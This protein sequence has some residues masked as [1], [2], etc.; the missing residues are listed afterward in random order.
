MISSMRIS[1]SPSKPQRVSSSSERV[2]MPLPRAGGDAREADDLVIP[3][4]LEHPRNM[5]LG[6]RLER[7]QVVRQRRVRRVELHDGLC[8]VTLLELLARA[9]P[10]GVVA[11]D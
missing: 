7:D 3:G 8:A 4:Q 2:A 11:A 1:S 9:A 5:R 6:E 10:A